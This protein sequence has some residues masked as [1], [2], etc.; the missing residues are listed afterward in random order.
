M[1]TERTE[2]QERAF[3]HM[4]DTPGKSLGLA[5]LNASSSAP[6]SNNEAISPPPKITRSS[7]PGFAPAPA[8]PIFGEG[9]LARQASPM[10]VNS[11]S[12]TSS[13]PALTGRKRGRSVNN[14]P[15]RSSNQRRTSKLRANKRK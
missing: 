11:L 5:M 6:E 4:D 8:I 15:N 1:G 2:T 9:V 3:T 10:T 7:L 12:S 13:S 14:K